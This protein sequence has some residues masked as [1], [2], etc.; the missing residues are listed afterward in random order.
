MYQL[1]IRLRTVPESTAKSEWVV[2]I[3]IIW[4]LYVFL[5]NAVCAAL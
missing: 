2:L 1:V 3:A 5:S 4:G